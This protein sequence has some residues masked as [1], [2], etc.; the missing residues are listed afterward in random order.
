ML[1]N[2]VVFKLNFHWFALLYSIASINREMLINK[3][4]VK[5]D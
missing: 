4:F 5:I 1:L 3:T 2:Q